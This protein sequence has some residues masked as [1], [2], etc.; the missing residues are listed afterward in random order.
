MLVESVEPSL[1]SRAFLRGTSYIMT[2]NVLLFASYADTL[3][4]SAIALDL[5]AG[6]TVRDLL[7][8][9]RE[10]PGAD[11]LPDEPL[12][13]VNDCYAKAAQVIAPG[14]EVA[15]IPPVAGG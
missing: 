10:F 11:R 15:I 3:G 1:S 7:A 13:A 6:A 9:V 12:V 8:L 5:E 14:D 4:T 2:V